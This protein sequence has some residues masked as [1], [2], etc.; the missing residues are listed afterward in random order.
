MRQ[1]SLL[2]ALTVAVLGTSAMV[3]PGA[4]AQSHGDT[5]QP[6]EPKGHGESHGNLEIWKWANFLL[7]AA[8][9]VLGCRRKPGGTMRAGQFDEHHRQESVG[10]RDRAGE[11]ALGRPPGGPPEQEARRHQQL[12]GKPGDD[13][14]PELGGAPPEGHG[15]CRERGEAEPVAPMVCA[16]EAVSAQGFDREGG[17]AGPSIIRAVRGGLTAPASGTR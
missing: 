3:P 10:V 1:V 13:R 15:E 2:A 5:K 8:G 9:S 17:A 14:E 6:G 4:H 12:G 16:R 7:L 11:P